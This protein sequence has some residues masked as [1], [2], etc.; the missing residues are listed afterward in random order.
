MRMKPK[1]MERYPLLLRILHWLI[2]VL[3]AAQLT[4]GFV[5][6]HGS[7]RETSGNLLELHFRLGILLFC[8]M[9]LRLALRL[10]M[11]VP[12][13]DDG[14]AGWI[15][16]VRTS[17]HAAFYVLVLALPISGHVIWVWMGADRSLFGGL[18]MPAFFVPP[19]DEAGRAFA[20]YVHVYGAWMLLALVGLHVTAA[21]YR[22]RIRADGFIGRRMG[23]GRTPVEASG[24][25]HDREGKVSSESA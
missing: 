21:L 8:L 4:L 25:A 3:L 1:S 2:A 18:T 17:V 12:V 10:R 11:S 7:A 5:A 22:Q 15:G 6:E 23:F 16:R 9:V 19:E 13:G 24:A 14:G 20:W